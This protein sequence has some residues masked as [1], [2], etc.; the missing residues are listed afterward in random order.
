MTARPPADY[1]LCAAENGPQPK[2]GTLPNERGNPVRLS[3]EERAQFKR[4][5]PLAILAMLA[6]AAILAYVMAVVP[7]VAVQS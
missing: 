3:P 6:I 5:L 4:E 1:V 2:L 7:A